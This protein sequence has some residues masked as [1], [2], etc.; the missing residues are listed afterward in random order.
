MAIPSDLEALLSRKQTAEALTAAGYPTSGATLATKATR[1]GGPPYSKYGPRAL[2][3]WG[4]ALGWA[5]SRL[6]PARGSTA[7]ADAQPNLGCDT[8]CAADINLPAHLHTKASSHHPRSTIPRCKP[9][10]P[11]AGPEGPDHADTSI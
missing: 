5:Q 8:A 11:H 2:Y 10:A 9:V 7:E 1:G 6:T 4:A 3:K